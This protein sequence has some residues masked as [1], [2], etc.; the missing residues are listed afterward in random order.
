MTI[1]SETIS[2][3]N[4]ARNEA[5]TIGELIEEAASH[6]ESVAVDAFW[7]ELRKFLPI[8]AIPTLP[9]L[10]AMSDSESREF[11]SR[12]MEFGKFAGT[13]IN[14]TP[15]EYLEWLADLPL[16][17]EFRRYLASRRIRAELED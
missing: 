8:K 7:D 12:L 10:T 2:L 5:A 11:G 13:R 3:R 4:K 16:A 17:R 9:G 14:E 15:L 1:D 6:T